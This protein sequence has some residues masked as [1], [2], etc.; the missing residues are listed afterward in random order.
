MQYIQM[1]YLV[2]MIREDPAANYEGKPRSTPLQRL[3]EEEAA[4]WRSGILAHKLLIGWVK[5]K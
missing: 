3:F 1:R 4:I 2:R 5:L